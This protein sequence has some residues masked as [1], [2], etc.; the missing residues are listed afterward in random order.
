M[1]SILLHEIRH[2]CN[3]LYPG[4]AEH[5][6]PSHGIGLSEYNPTADASQGGDLEYPDARAYNRWVRSKEDPADGSQPQK[7][8]V[9]TAQGAANYACDYMLRNLATMIALMDEFDQGSSA[10][11]SGAPRDAFNRRKNQNAQHFRNTLRKIGQT[12]GE[13]GPLFWAEKKPLLMQYY[14][15]L[16]GRAK[17]GYTESLDRALDIMDRDRAL[18]D[19][20]DWV[21]CMDPAPDPPTTGN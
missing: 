19:R 6:D 1:L 10:G 14:S 11:L 18:P 2:V 5:P 21:G 4:S 17:W 3:G 16:T 9:T 15:E 8:G 12:M 7:S 20:E 13:G